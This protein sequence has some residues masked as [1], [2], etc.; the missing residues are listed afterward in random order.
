MLISLSPPC[1]A[2]QID[3]PEELLELPHIP[4]VTIHKSDGRRVDVYV[5]YTAIAPPP[6]PLEAADVTDEEDCY[7]WYTWPR[8]LRALRH[9]AP[10][11]AALRTIACRRALAASRL[12]SP[13]E[14]R[15]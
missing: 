2:K 7:D 6:G 4:P 3:Y 5:L 1:I 10:A 12:R 14:L 13:L 8:A 11:A 15:S 9:D